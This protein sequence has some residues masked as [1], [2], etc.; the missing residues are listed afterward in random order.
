MIVIIDYGMGKLGSIL[1]MLKKIGI[2]AKISSNIE[3]INKAKKLILQG[4]G[5]FDNGINSLREGG[6][7]LFSIMELLRIKFQF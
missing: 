7:N 2:E 1:N 3:D 5:S 6:W 4:L